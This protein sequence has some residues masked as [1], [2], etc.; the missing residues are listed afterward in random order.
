M[1]AWTKDCSLQL[2]VEVIPVDGIVTR[3][4]AAVVNRFFQELLQAFL[5]PAS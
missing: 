4:R 1:A 2:S 5:K 3:T